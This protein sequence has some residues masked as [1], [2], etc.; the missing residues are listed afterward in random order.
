VET[1]WLP[2]LEGIAAAQGHYLWENRSLKQVAAVLARCRLYVGGDSGLT[3]LAAAVGAPAVLALFGPTDPAIWAPPGEH[4][5]VLTAPGQ[6][7]P[8]AQARDITCPAP[9]CLED[10]TPARVLAAAGALLPDS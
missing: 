3:H 4:V 1:G 2:Y 8:C 6:C 5:T 9:R 7:V 10:L